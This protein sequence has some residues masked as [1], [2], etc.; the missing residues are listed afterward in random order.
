[1]L[2]ASHLVEKFT[3]FEMFRK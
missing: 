2:N 1:M 3:D